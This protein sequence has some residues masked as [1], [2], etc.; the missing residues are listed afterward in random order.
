MVFIDRL[1]RDLVRRPA[2][3]PRLRQALFVVAVL[4]RKIDRDAV[5]V[6]AGTLS[7][8]SLV[9]LV[10]GLILM[11]LV[12]RAL[13]LE[14]WFS[15]STF[16]GRALTAVLPE[17]DAVGLPQQVDAKTIGVAGLVVAFAAS[18]RIFLAAEEAYNRIWNTR[19]QKPLTT[20]LALYYATLTLA[21]AVTAFG[22]SLTARA[23]AA[24]SQQ[25]HQFGPFLVTM[26]A[27]TFAIRAL[28]DAT[29]RMRSALIGGA[30]SALA[31]EATKGG[32]AA[33]IGVFKSSGAAALVYGSLAFVPIL[34][35]WV[36]VVWVIILVGVEVACVDQRWPEL[37]R[38][39]GRLV[40]G[41]DKRTPD[42]FFA[43]QCMVAVARRFAKGAGPATEPMVTGALGSDPDHVQTALETLEDAGLL[44]RTPR[45][46][47]P[48]V[49]LDSLTAAEVVRRYRER[50]HPTVDVNAP[51][52]ELAA[53]AGD[54]PALQRVL[55]ELVRG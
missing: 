36:F 1:Y 21:P 51:G 18:T 53:A 45:G 5:F 25:F 26:A 50:S 28:P 34:L 31:F 39:E 30:V 12:L 16:A 38:A 29:V 43:L 23:E 3:A 49:P 13:G 15:F 6:R 4:V 41:A 54:A 52:A 17:W 46:W 14:S 47:T 42:A 40:E 20:R 35:L 22:F 32:F 24:T 2:L 11:A 10:P 19:A 37:R 8:W 9:A 48:S 7:Y 27:F 44:E 55:S 33:Y